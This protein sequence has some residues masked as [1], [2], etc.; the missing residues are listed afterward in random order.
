MLEL[1]SHTASD[2]IP[3]P[4]IGIGGE[5]ATVSWLLLLII[6][7]HALLLLLQLLCTILRC[8]LRLWVLPRRLGLD[9]YPFLPTPLP[10][11]PAKLLATLLPPL[12]LPPIPQNPLIA[13]P[14]QPSQ[15][16][17]KAQNNQAF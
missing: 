9:L 2:P 10:L 6:Q 14:H 8:L 15:H 1:V 3:E 11:R 13:I 4:G 5:E 7:R 17:H 16:A 12:P